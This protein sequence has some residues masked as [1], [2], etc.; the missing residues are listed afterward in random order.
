MQGEDDYPGL[1][2]PRRGRAIV[3]ISFG[4]ALVVI[5][6]AIPTVALPTIARELAVSSAV[7]TNVVTVYQL[8]L[9]M[10]L[11]PFSALGDRVGHRTLYQW[12]QGVFMLAS[13]ACLLVDQFAGLLLLRAVQAV[14]AAMV[15]SVS[16]AM[17]RQIYPASHLGTGMGINGVIVSSSAALAPTLGG[18]IV[19]N[20]AWQLVFVVAAPL[21]L[22]SLVLGRALPDPAPRPHQQVQWLSSGLSA[23][24]MLALVGGLQLATHGDVSAGMI[25]VA[26][27]AALLW[28]LVRRER[29]QA[30]PVLPVDLLA[31]PAIGLS[32][33][34]SMTSFIAAGTLLL[35]LPFRLEGVLG[36]S[37]AEVGM[38][39]L[40]YPLT[41]MVVAPLAGWASDRVAPT[42]LGVTGL[43]LVVAGLLLLATMPLA[44]DEW[45][46]VWRLMLIALGF[47][48]FLSPNARLLFSRT[49]RERT[50][51]AGGLVSTSR[52]FGQTLAAVLVGMLLASGF[53]DGPVPLL[54][55]SLLVLVAIGCSLTRYRLRPQR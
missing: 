28:L 20:A 29:Q 4:S 26:A 42:K 8:V 54:L 23:L 14:G 38:L 32:A 43:S 9:V 13:A 33:L 12:G 45:A 6:G 18:W 3:A 24:T 30:A 39:L 47:G 44:R 49:P 51:A 41:M 55:A 34:A 21:A 7:V 37:P 50:A 10:L 15:L 48:L 31:Q 16:A 53:A 19:G 27:G 35:V 52:L 17:M 36:Y 11:L 5:D 22:L 2:Q 40:P 25:V 46:L 1:P